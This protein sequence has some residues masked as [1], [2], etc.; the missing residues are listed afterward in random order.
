MLDR[1]SDR[2]LARTEDESEYLLAL[3]LFVER[4][5]RAHEPVPAAT[6]V[7]MLAYLIE[8]HGVKQG[9]VAAGTGLADSTIS[10]ILAG[11]RKMN[12]KHI[13]ALA[14][15]FKVEPAVFLDESSASSGPVFTTATADRLM[16]PT[17]RGRPGPG[18]RDGHHPGPR[19]GPGPRRTRTGDPGKRT[20]RRRAG[21]AR[22]SASLHATASRAIC[23]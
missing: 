16:P 18:A 14:Q 11:K 19:S 20:G 1:L 2:G 6:G 7:E 8:T 3:A 4:Y 22:I 12:V 10:E 13:E 9:E 15:F 17:R 21:T 5:E 23:R